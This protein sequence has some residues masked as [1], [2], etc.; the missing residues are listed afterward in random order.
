MAN[1]LSKLFGTKSQRDLKEVQPF[2]EATL[3]IYPEIQKLDNDRLRGKT[4][5]FKARIREAVKEEEEIEIGRASC[6]ERV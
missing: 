3:K 5:E 2:L 1:F 4:D 6:R